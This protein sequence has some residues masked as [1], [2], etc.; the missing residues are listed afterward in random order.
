M[1]PR[2][3]HGVRLPFLPRRLDDHANGQAL[4]PREL[5]ISLVVRGHAHH[6]ARPVLHQHVGG[7][8]AGHALVVH[9]VHCVD[10]QDD[11]VPALGLFAARERRGLEAIQH[12]AS[13]GGD[14]TGFGELHHQRMLQREHEE[15]HAPE[16]V[17]PGGEHVDRVAGLI[18]P[19]RHAR[20]LRPPDPVA[21]HVQDAIGPLELLHVVQEALGVV[22]DPEEPLREVLAH[23]GCTASLARAVD[24]LLVGQ[25]RL[26]VRAPVGRR[27]LPVR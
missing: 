18:D 14:A 2:L 23:D 22:G 16:R 13:L 6:R 19:E 10:P 5:E 9:G 11:A 17:G 25:D 7:H 4:G 24:H 15:A 21:L 1:I 20:A 3:G 27:G 26:V 12:L 8:V